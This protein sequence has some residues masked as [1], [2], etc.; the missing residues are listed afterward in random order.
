MGLLRA[1][2]AVVVQPFFY[3]SFRRK[4]KLLEAYTAWLSGGV[5]ILQFGRK[6]SSFSSQ[7]AP[8]FLFRAST[9]SRR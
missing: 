5:T 6:R 4:E 2:G 7:A 1:L 9:A 8:V 3:A